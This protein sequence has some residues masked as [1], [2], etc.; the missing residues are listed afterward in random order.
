MYYVRLFSDN[1]FFYNIY[2]ICLIFY[3]LPISNP[4]QE[5][6]LLIISLFQLI[7]KKIKISFASFIQKEMSFHQRSLRFSISQ[8]Q[9]LCLHW[10]CAYFSGKEKCLCW[11]RSIVE[12]LP[13]HL[14]TIILGKIKGLILFIIDNI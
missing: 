8:W 4:F 9:T 3:S 1:N 7:R 5:G 10:K 6:K 12:E 13:H 2:K 11:L 14:Y